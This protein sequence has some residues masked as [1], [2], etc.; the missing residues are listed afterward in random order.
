MA[1]YP[2]TTLYPGALVFPDTSTEVSGD[3]Q[4]STR[5]VV[6][7]AAEDLYASLG[8]WREMDENVWDLL[9]LCEAAAGKLQEVYDLGF[10][11]DLVG[12]SQVMDPDAAPA[13]FVPWLGQFIGVRMLPSDSLDVQR[14]RIRT[15]SG[16][17]RGTPVALIA[18]VKTQL[19]GGDGTVVL[20]E[21]DT[22]AY[23]A[24]VQTY[25][26]QT[27]NVQAVLDAIAAAKPAGL[28][29]AHQLLSG[30]TFNQVNALATDFNNEKAIWPTFDDMTHQVP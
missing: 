6:S 29:V 14:Q 13:K 22:S 30:I 12:W 1:L 16:W 9:L 7:Q 15:H 26:A 2:D 10:R 17:E 3:P 23:H 20:I 21:R 19:A 11:E 24:T 25:T 28:V 27:P 18:A 8:P 5:P 4:G